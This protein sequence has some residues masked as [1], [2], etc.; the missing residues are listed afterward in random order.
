M[1]EDLSD[2]VRI[3]AETVLS[4]KRYRLSEYAIDYRR[5]DG[6]WQ[7]QSREVFNRGDAA[8]ILP[9]D[10]ERGMV[11]LVSQFRLPAFLTGHAEPLIEAI[12]GA[13]D[14][15]TPEACAR[16]EAMEEAGLEVSALKLVSHCFMSPG[17]IT[18]RISLFVG[19]YR[20]A[21]AGGGLANE[22]E[23]IA[24]LEMPLAEALAMVDS[25]AICDAKTIVLLQHLKLK[26]L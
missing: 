9:F 20:R 25:G 26:G 23:D 15:D 8:S 1:S 13:L 10:P 22:G 5:G 6:T 16:R 12:A 18:E 21:Q 2:R 11:V 3:R 24:V 14:G 19:R 7:S 4:H 17:A